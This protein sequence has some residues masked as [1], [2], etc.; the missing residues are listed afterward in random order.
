[1]NENKVPQF[2]VACG[3]AKFNDPKHY[4]WTMG[5]RPVRP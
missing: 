5:F 3:A 2:F 4:P 1:M